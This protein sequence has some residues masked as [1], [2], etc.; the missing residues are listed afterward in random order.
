MFTLE[1]VKAAHAKVRSGADFPKYI[2]EIKTLGLRRYEFLVSNG[3]TVYYGDAA[4]KI[5]SQ[6]MY[7]PLA[8]AET[9]SAADLRHTIAIHQQGQTDF[10]TF[11]VQAAAAGVE[12]WVID[13]EKMVCTYVDANGGTMVE[14]PIPAVDHV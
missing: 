10:M 7:A 4:T 8:I 14:E 13:T 2:Q 11:C 5:A 1:Q 6:P 9:P 12:K 3:E